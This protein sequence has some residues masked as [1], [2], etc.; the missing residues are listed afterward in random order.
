[1]IGNDKNFYFNVYEGFFVWNLIVEDVL[2]VIECMEVQC[3]QLIVQGCV[4]R[5]M[6]YFYLVNFYVDQYDEVI[7]DKLLVFLII[8]VFVEVLLLQVIL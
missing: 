5:V 7:K 1:M 3:C 8:L 4:F 2:D 6:Y